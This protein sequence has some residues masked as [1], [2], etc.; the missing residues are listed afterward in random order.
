MIFY[1]R[2]KIFFF[3]ALLLLYVTPLCILPGKDMPGIPLKHT[4]CHIFYT[5]RKLCLWGDI[6]FS[7][8]LSVR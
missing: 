2:K 4:F 8:C 5:P 7:H 6:V 3:F 1:S